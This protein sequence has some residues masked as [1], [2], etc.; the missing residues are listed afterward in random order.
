MTVNDWIVILQPPEEPDRPAS[1]KGTLSKASGASLLLSV[2]CNHQAA[3]HGFVLRSFGW[4]LPPDWCNTSCVLEY[5]A[6]LCFNTHGNSPSLPL[7]HFH[8]STAIVYSYTCQCG[9]L[10][11]HQSLCN[12]F[13]RRESFGDAIHVDR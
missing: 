13:I 2:L 3:H 5:L 8:S 11:E 4:M 7:G 10:Q 1:T 12:S 6:M 9:C